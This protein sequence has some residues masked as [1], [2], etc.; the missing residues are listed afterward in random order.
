MKKIIII[1][2]STLILNAC[3]KEES[4]FYQA[5]VEYRRCATY[6]KINNTFYRLYN[7]EI[8]NGQKIIKIK[9]NNILI[10]TSTNCKSDDFITSKGTIEITAIK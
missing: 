2:L 6:V 3:K 4:R 9:F 7:K 10:C 5:T 1:A 8:L